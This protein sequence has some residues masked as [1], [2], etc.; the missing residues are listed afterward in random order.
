MFDISVK[1]YVV[2][3]HL[4]PKVNQYFVCE[5]ACTEFNVQADLIIC[6]LFIFEFAYM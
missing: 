5:L 3:F 2:T 1:F 4:G 6:D